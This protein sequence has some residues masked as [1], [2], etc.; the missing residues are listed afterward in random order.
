LKDSL[1]SIL[2]T[3]TPEAGETERH[4]NGIN[5]DE[6]LGSDSSYQAPGSRSFSSTLAYVIYTSGS[7]GK[8]K[9]TLIEHW[10]VVNRINWM[11]KRYPIAPGDVILQKTPTTFDVSVW[12]L[13]WW[14]WYGA[15]LSLLAPGGE[16]E[17]AVI[18]DTIDRTGVS[19]MHFVPS[20]L[21]SFLGYLEDITETDNSSLTT[22]RRVFAS[23]EALTGKQVQKFYQHMNRNSGTRLSNLYGPTEATVDVS[24]YDC[25]P[26]HQ[27]GVPIGK[28]IDNTSL[29][30]LDKAKGLLPV[31][32]PGELHIAGDGLSRGYLNKPELTAQKFVKGQNIASIV[33]PPLS[34]GLSGFQGAPSLGPRR[35]RREA[36]RWHLYSTG[37]L[38]RWQPDG[39]IEYL[40]RIDHQVKIRGF[41]I[42]LGEIENLL[43]SKDNITE[44]I[45]VAKKDRENN[46]YLAAYYVQNDPGEETPREYLSEKLPDYMIPSYFVPLEKFPLTPNGKI[47]RKALP[48]P[49]DG[50]RIAKE[51]QAPTNEIEEKLVEIWQDVLGLE[52]I[53]ITDNFFE[54]GGHSLKAINII[55]KIMRTFQVELLLTTLFKKPFIKDLA[56][57]ISTSETAHFTAIENIEKKDYYPVSAAQKR[58]FALNRFAP[59][60]VNYN[61]PGGL[62]IEGEFSPVHFEEVFQTLIHRHESLRTSFFLTDGEP[63]Q[64]VYKPGSIVFAV[65]FSELSERET[66]EQHLLARFLRPFDFSR[67]PLLRVELVQLEEKKH[68]FLF[69]MHHIISDGV[70]TD[71]LVKEFSALYAGEALKPLTHSYKDYAVWQNRF[72]A[73]PELL[74][75][76]KYW[77]EKFS[78]EIPVLNMPTDYPRPVIRSFEGE[79]VPF[80]INEELTAQLHRMAGKHGATIYMVLLALFNIL[81]S[82]YSRQEDI[83]VGSP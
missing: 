22:L 1:A 71:I 4:S 26:D 29:H 13:F 65:T 37:D 70:S 50:A 55:A 5:I 45:V 43:L 52:K 82:R 38:A 41:R 66:Q 2:L 17:P 75:Q 25:Q 49:G 10:S 20:M 35:A 3:T 7:T 31:G 67:A 18:I 24:Y 6:A 61:M 53:G 34:E 54:I 73:S 57:N 19:T 68:L 16:K 15:R 56:Q 74:K 77:Q 9:G 60:S 78:D 46:Y 63:V 28:P 81:L 8:P 58:M 79:T 39:N 59:D 11:Q 14:S 27:A 32:V 48:E 83:I 69:D 36:R 80:E 12:E 23:G 47:D 62:V 33:T 21:G 42:E 40:G 51:Y 76:K 72:M 44:A 30:I 64:R